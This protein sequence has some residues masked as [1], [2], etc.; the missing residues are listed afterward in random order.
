MLYLRKSSVA[1]AL[2]L[3]LGACSGGGG[4][5]SSGDTGSG[6]NNGGTSGD[7]TWVQ[8]TFADAGVYKNFCANPRGGTS[9]KTGTAL[10][11][12]MWLRSWTNETYLWYSEVPDN[13]P[14]NFNTVEAYFDQLKTTQTTSSG[15]YKDRFHGSMSTEEWEALSNSG[16][17]LG[18]GVEF[19]LLKASPPRQI[20]AAYTE[21]GSQAANAGILRGAEFL[22]AN[23][24]DV[25]YSNDVDALNAA[26][27]PTEK[28]KA[29]TFKIRDMNGTERTVSLTANTVTQVPVQNVKAITTTSGKVGYL[30]FNSHI[31]TA[32]GALVTAIDTLKAQGVTDL[33]LDVRYNG[34]GLLAIASQLGY[35]IAGPSR[36]SNKIFENTT[37]NDKHTSTNPVTGQTLVPMPFINTGV[38]FSYSQGQALPYLGLGR[39]FVLTTAATCSASEAIINGLRG[40]DLD[41]VQIGNRTCGKPYGF[42]PTDNCGTTYFSIQFRGENDKGF[43]DYA[44]GF[45]PRNSPVLSGEP[46][47]GCNLADDFTKQLGDPAEAMLAAAL[48]YRLDGSCP[49]AAVAQFA[50]S[51]VTQETVEGDALADG[52]ELNVFRNNRVMTLPQGKSQ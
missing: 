22:E 16:E 15:A 31:A 37:F 51:R 6:G 42:Y 45:E 3:T 35:M 8:G 39:V 49:A 1:I 7:I 5:S 24:V 28:G 9:D 43:G 23:G 27:F 32:E 4:D 20:V 41:V 34:G 19:Q 26:F 21:P 52:R 33:V 50:P 40:I 2:M 46:V 48:Q 47:N 12:K 29:S 13:N 11:E 17:S 10:H 14:S 44:D 38:G 18:Y 36:T 30:Q 25:V